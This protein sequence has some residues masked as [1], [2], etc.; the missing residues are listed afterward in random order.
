MRR[1][2]TTRVTTALQGLMLAALLVASASCSD[3]RAVG[4]LQW[5]GFDECPGPALS[6]EFTK[7]NVH[8][9]DLLFV[10]DNSN[11]MA[12]EQELLKEQFGAL[13]QELRVL[14]YRMPDMHIGV[15]ST[16]LGMDPYEEDGCPTLG[17]DQGR[18]LRRGM[19]C[20]NVLTHNFVVDVQPVGCEIFRDEDNRTC[21]GHDCGP[22]SCAQEPTTSLV[23]DEHGCPRCVNY[24]NEPLEY[25]FKCLALVGVGGCGFELLR[26]G[27]QHARRAQLGLHFELQPGLSGDPRGHRKRHSLGPGRPLPRDPAGRL[28]RPRGGCRAAGGRADLQRPVRGPVLCGG[29]VERRFAL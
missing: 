4:N 19:S 21:V 7:P 23:E 15:T 13:M 2:F 14:G 1:S 9:V 12:A 10:V 16:D 17:G 24:H 3:D 26:T 18:L 25:A 28:L 8:E 27:L 20:D 22:A 5:G 11:S 6:S 29:A